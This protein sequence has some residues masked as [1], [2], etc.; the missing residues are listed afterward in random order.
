MNREQRRNGGGAPILQNGH[1]VL[2]LD[3]KKR[4]IQIVLVQPEFIATLLTMNIEHVISVEGWPDGAEIVDVGLAPNGSYILT[5]YHPD[6][7]FL[8]D[9]V[10]PKVIQITVHR[11]PLN[12]PEHTGE[13]GC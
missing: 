1:H 11:R 9:G 13:E 3:P 6:F 4:R 8:L 5:L 7:P 2:E 10:A 12:P